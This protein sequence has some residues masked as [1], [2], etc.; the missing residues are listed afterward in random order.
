MRQILYAPVAQ[1]EELLRPKERVAGSTPVWGARFKPRFNKAGLIFYGFAVLKE[2]NMKK[3]LFLGVSSVLFAA[4]AM[5][6]TEVGNAFIQDT[7]QPMLITAESGKKEGR[8]CAKNILG[9]Y[10]SG[11]MSV[12]AAKKNGGITKV[13]S[14]NKE[15]KSYAIYAEVCTVV[16]GR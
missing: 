6:A 14:V 4:C 16:I 13:A 8:A 7:V 12:E 15:I 11:D 2:S 1:L 3:L 9:L 10:L 5:P